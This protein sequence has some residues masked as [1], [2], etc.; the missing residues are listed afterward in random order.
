MVGWECSCC[1]QPVKTVLVVSGHQQ[2]ILWPL[3]LVICKCFLLVEVLICTWVTPWSQ[4][5]FMDGCLTSN[6]IPLS[7]I[8]LMMCFFCYMFW[9]VIIWHVLA[10]L[11]L[12]LLQLMLICTI[13]VNLKWPLIFYTY[14]FSVNYSRFI[15]EHNWGSLCH[16]IKEKESKI[17]I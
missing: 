13:S 14:Y 10:W 12:V 11:C 7:K 2:A 17:F 5:A 4:N 1:L 9:S 16:P 15:C 3:W 8:R 6:E